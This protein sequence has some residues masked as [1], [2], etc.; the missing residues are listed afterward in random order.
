MKSLSKLDCPNDNEKSIILNSNTIISSTTSYNINL[1]VVGNLVV[2]MFRTLW[3]L[4]C[5]YVESIIR[6]K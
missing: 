3:K 6:E 4:F 2:T 1:S 5:I